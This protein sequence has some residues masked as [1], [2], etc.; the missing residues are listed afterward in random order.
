MNRTQVK[1]ALCTLA[2]SG[3]SYS[4]VA[5]RHSVAV[6]GFAGGAMQRNSVSG[7]DSLSGS[8]TS[9]GLRAAFA[10][11]PAVELELAYADFGT[12]ED[13]GIDEFGDLIT[14]TLESSA[15]LAGIKGSFP[16]GPNVSLLGR[17]GM[18][19]WDVD[20][21]QT[22]SAFP[23]EAYTDHDKGVDLYFGA[24]VQFNLAKNMYLSVDYTSLNVRASLGDASTRHDISNFGVALG[25][26]F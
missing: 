9:L 23:G 26:A 3:T 6:E 12:A 14:D 21:R 5:D 18:A 24:G 20:Y 15:K 17:A 8:D 19:L 2:L 25:V 10:I 16:L 11:N 4:A 7:F 1:A 13:S 22:D